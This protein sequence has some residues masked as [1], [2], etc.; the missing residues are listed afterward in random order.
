LH[1][2]VSVRATL[3]GLAQV[4]DWTLVL[5]TTFAL[6]ALA[7]IFLASSFVHNGDSSLDEGLALICAFAG[8]YFFARRIQ[9]SRPPAPAHTFDRTSQEWPRC[10]ECGGDKTPTDEGLVC[11]ICD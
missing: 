8:L 10:V 6:L 4:L 1:K 11:I 7:L 9:A 5:F 3:R 2:V